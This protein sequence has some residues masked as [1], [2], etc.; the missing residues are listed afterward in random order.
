MRLTQIKLAGFKS[1]VD[2]TSFHIPGKLVGVVGP[3]GCGKSNIIDATRWVLGESKASELRGESMQDVIFNG[4]TGRK[5][6]GRASV[7][8][9]FDNAMGRAAGQ[10]SQYAEISVKRVLTR[11]GT[12]TYYINN[13]PVRRRDVQDIFMGTGLGPR[14][15]AII[16][17]GMI[18]RIIEA[19]PDELRVFLEEAAGV[20]KYKERRRETENRL[21]D[22]RENLTR[23]EDILRELA[24]NLEKL[25]AQ[26]VVAE[27][28][29]ALQDEGD[30]K[31]KMLWTLRRRDAAAE[32]ER[33]ARDIEQSQVTLDSQTADLRAVEAKLETLRQSHYAASDAL[34]NAQGGVF[35]VNN[36]I[37]KLEAD[38]RYVID[39]RRRIEEAL[40]A[41]AAQA[42]HWKRQ[43][44]EQSIA[45]ED[46]RASSEELQVRAEEA[47]AAAEH[48]GDS[49]PAL[50]N[51]VREGRDRVAELRTA[52][53]GVQQGLQLE[54]AQQSNLSARIEDLSA[55]RD[56]LQQETKGL[57]AP[58]AERLASQSEH[59]E[60][61]EARLH[62]AQAHLDD[63][64]AAIPEHEQA[65]RTAADTVQSE[66][67]KLHQ[68]EARLAALK[69]LQEDV[70][71]RG[72]LEPWL[73]KHGLAQLP[74]LWQRIDIE[75]GWEAALESALRERVASLE[76][77]QLDRAKA[78][79]HDAPPA[80]L[81]FIAAEHVAATPAA[82]A[83][84]KPL[85]SL[86]RLNDANLRALLTE[87]LANVYAV[88]SIDE[89]IAQRDQLPVGAVFVVPSGH[90]VGRASISFYAA[91]DEQA[92][93]LARQHEIEN[94][95]KQLRAHAMLVEEARSAQVR[96]DAA[97]T[98]ATEQA[99]EWRAKVQ[100]T[101]RDAHQLQL[102]V[103]K[104]TQA[105]EQYEA[106]SSRLTGELEEISAQL[107]DLRASL[108]E[109]QQRFETLDAQLGDAQMR[110][111]DEQLAQEARE[112]K[113]ADARNAVRDRERAAQEAQ[114]AVRNQASRI[115]ELERSIRFATEQHANALAQREKEQ[116]AL[117]ELDDEA[118]QAGL[119]DALARKTDAEE[120]LGRARDELETL[121]AQL[122]AADE[123]R[124]KL[125]RGLEPANQRI[126]DLRLKEQAARLNEEQYAQQLS[127]CQADE[128]ALLE[129]LGNDPPKASWLQGEV[130]RINNE[131]EALGA[132]NLAAL[133]ELKT[134]RERKEFLDAQ[135]KDLVEAITT[136][137]DA[138]RKIDVETRALLKG[139][140][141]TVNEHFGRLF[142]ELFGGGTAKL[143]ITGDEILDA[144]VQVMAHPPGKK[145][146]T[147][148]L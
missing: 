87:W 96:A 70:L 74:K 11:D 104:L 137:E 101:T 133:D 19:K 54:S 36:A 14:A 80:K 98:H 89:A 35:E 138:I 82:P 102:E 108:E 90:V 50:E 143:V 37:A 110:A 128:A 13:H 22:T 119:Q 47:A 32:R 38:I 75:T 131:I 39:S 20:S 64:Q 49:L 24:S 46:A 129:A 107:E 121:T 91:D 71:H 115:E 5:P 51:E 95:G 45:L 145:N 106:R 30:R 109:S 136:L 132:V 69:R 1:F 97:Y 116:A 105:K 27:K 92:G 65:R 23:V 77:G 62:E 72:K 76:I 48:A 103:L 26:A 140:F 21:H 31:Q 9:V 2:P 120:A 135:Q 86:L 134:A 12:S 4:S 142:P 73:E 122:R 118:A 85:L 125:E 57:Q 93:M 7:E 56:R 25:D 60:A 55:R 15:Y 17:Q 100:Q 78:F 81:T 6:A 130:T 123:E 44:E 63:A 126:M 29:R 88:N 67:Q 59:L 68:L 28:Y 66:N 99:T 114:F 43:Q 139:T 83:G 146:S 147:I 52:A 33:I 40:V 113:L 16:G 94:L 79:L 148:H 141:D 112:T 34:H 8:L 53:M 61:L 124:L 41:L 3:N 111:E 144:G 18:S 84:L 58:D 117:A 127:E 42:E 10:W